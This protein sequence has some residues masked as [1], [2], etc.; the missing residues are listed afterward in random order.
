MRNSVLLTAVSL[1]VLGLV[2]GD[3]FAQIPPPK[4]AE[5]M[6]S[7]AYRGPSY[8]PY[9]ARNFATHPLW[10]DTHLHTGNSF[11]AG[12]FGATLMPEDAFRFARGDEVVSSTGIPIRLS[13]PLDWLAVTDHSDNVGFFP[14]LRAGNENILSVPS[15]FFGGGICAKTSLVPGTVFRVSTQASC[16]CPFPVV[17]HTI[18]NA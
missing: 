2:A 7:E 5:G 6:L 4:N 18:F 8:S 12:A 3:V 10:G 16:S 11:D 17:I 15:A 13:R 14:D 1:I 9:A